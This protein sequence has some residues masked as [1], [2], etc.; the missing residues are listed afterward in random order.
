MAIDTLVE[1]GVRL[2][3]GNSQILHLNNDFEYAELAFFA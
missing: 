1:E 2:L 3:P